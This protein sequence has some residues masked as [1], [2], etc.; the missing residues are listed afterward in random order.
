MGS[1][2][3][4]PRVHLRRLTVGLVATA[5]L[6]GSLAGCSGSSRQSGQS[7]E[8]P[9]SHT[10]DA[11]QSEAQLLQSSQ[12]FGDG[13]RSAQ[14]PLE[15]VE[16]EGLPFQMWLPKGETTVELATGGGVEPAK[17]GHQYR[18]LGSED[19]FTVLALFDDGTPFGTGRTA[20]QA[21]PAIGV[22]D[23][24]DQ[25]VPI[26]S[27]TL[28]AVRMLPEA[29][30]FESLQP[31]RAAT[32]GPV[33]VWTA[34]G[35]GGKQWS[36]LSW[37]RETSVVVELASS[38]SM[39]LDFSGKNLMSNAQPP[40]VN[41]GHAYF[42][43][44]IP[45]KLFEAAK[46]GVRFH[47]LDVQGATDEE[48]RVA[49]FRVP[50]TDPGDV[51]FVGPS[52][53]I[54]LDPE[55]IGGLF[56]SATPYGGRDHDE[57]LVTPQS[58]EE[59]RGSGSDWPQAV[60]YLDL[61]RSAVEEKPSNGGRP[62]FIVWGDGRTVTPLFGFSSSDKWVT[63]D[64]AASEQHLVVAV[65]S[66][67]AIEQETA[68]KA[69]TASWL[70]VWNLAAGEVETV[71]PSSVVAPS[72]VA[73]ED[74]LVWGP[75]EDPLED[76]GKDHG[77]KGRLGKPLDPAFAWEIGGEA[78]YRLPGGTTGIGPFLAGSD[79]AV[80]DE[81]TGSVSWKFLRWM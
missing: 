66:V 76:P 31:V 68:S 69:S 49:T 71:V 18:L 8:S 35:A 20:T 13:T 65:S 64:I 47:D 80:S 81:D 61:F 51:M 39:M 26:E 19:D 15:P 24:L 45:Q 59:D 78:I 62:T 48:V 79:I 28:K 3:H 1:V 74:L 27:S 57:D 54:A 38:S 7:A 73:S 16:V 37:N 60:P 55:Y 41:G 72:L 10:E 11:A 14:L 56:W 44:A 53:Q 34:V 17:A 2:A 21:T 50:L 77:S 58:G 63:T 75:S 5:A 42:E 33:V 6:I 22:L 52:S 23:P 29:A 12:I 36:L 32:W 25:F 43:V 70:I 9:Q 67:K 30:P 4:G 46:P 40:A